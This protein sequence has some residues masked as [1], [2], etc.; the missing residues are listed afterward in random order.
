[1][2]CKPSTI[3]MNITYYHSFIALSDDISLPDPL[4]VVFS[5]GQNTSTGCITITIT[6]DEEFE[7]DHYFTVSITSA[8]TVP[9]AVVG[10]PAVARVTILDDD[11]GMLYSFVL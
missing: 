9:Y 8:G 6:R 5:V 11:G 4:Q 1:M 3:N 2:S 10:S 7:E